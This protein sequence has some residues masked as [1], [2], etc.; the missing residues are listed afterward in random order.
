MHAMSKNSG[1]VIYPGSFDPITNGHL[2]L[3]ERSLHIFDYV[4]VGVANN[5]DKNAAVH[6]GGAQ[7]DDPR[8]GQLQ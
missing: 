6:R 7:G 5:P 2:D 1:K 4:I 8:R 3:I